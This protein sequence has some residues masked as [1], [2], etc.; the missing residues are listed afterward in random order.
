[1]Q[2]EPTEIPDVI[3][4]KPKIFSDERGYFSE[5]YRKEL[6]LEHGIDKDFV[7]DNIS[8][9]VKGTLRG[10]HYQIENPQAKLVM[11]TH[12][13]ILDVAVDI[14]KNSPTFGKHVIAELSEENK[15]LLYIPEGFAHGFYV[16]TD[17]AVFQYKCGDYYNPNGERGIIWNDP[18]IGIDWPEG[19]KILSGKD[20]KLPKLAE[21]KEDDIPVLSSD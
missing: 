2:F 19:N 8:K 6:F 4:I 11:A 21:L 20:E 12:G 9:S 1:M 16:L 17:S 13:A 3:L 5:T 14:R 15:N 10:L 18:E 7:Q